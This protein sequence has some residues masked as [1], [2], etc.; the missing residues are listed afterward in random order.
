MPKPANIPA[1]VGVSGERPEVNDWVLL[2]FAR[3]LKSVTDLVLSL[4]EDGTEAEILGLGFLPQ[5][6]D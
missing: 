3:G 4:R 2:L 6:H 5:L 1:E